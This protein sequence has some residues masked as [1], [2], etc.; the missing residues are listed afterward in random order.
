MDLIMIAVKMRITKDVKMREIIL[1]VWLF[2]T[3]NASFD[4]YTAGVS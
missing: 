1:M 2:T 3:N 4:N